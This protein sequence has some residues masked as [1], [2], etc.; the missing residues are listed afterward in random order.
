MT[1]HG[2]DYGRVKLGEDIPCFLAPL[3]VPLIVDRF[4]HLFMPDVYICLETELWPLVIGKAK[5]SGAAVI[6]LNGRISD[7]SIAAYRRFRPLF[8]AVLENFDEIGVISRVDSQRFALLGAKPEVITITGNIKYD[9]LLPE[10]HL[11]IREKQRDLLGVDK[12]TDVFIAGSTHDPEEELLLPI[13]ERLGKKSNQLW[14]IAPRHLDRV[15]QIK[16]TLTSGKINYDLFSRIKNA[17]PRQHSLVLIDT[18]GDLAELYSIASFV[19]I[20]GSF[21]DYGGHNLMEAAVWGNVLFFG[22]FM[23]DFQEAADVFVNAGGGICVQSPAAL[24]EQ[25]SRFSTDRGLLSEI[26]ARTETAARKQQ[27]AALRQTELVIRHL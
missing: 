2:R 14:L 1:L 17:E 6:L 7:R 9:A 4:L 11:E 20:G 16:K 13:Y 27:R 19:F 5:R 3:D 21:T 25:L 15:E 10:D 26:S 12:N 23:Q 8:R 22:P 24:E 18:F